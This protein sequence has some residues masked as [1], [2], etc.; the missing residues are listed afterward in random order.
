MDILWNVEIR[1]KM[2][3]LWLGGGG[4]DKN[5]SRK[6]TGHPIAIRLYNQSKY[7]I[8]EVMDVPQANLSTATLGTH[9]HMHHQVISSYLENAPSVRRASVTNR[10]RASINPRNDSKIFQNGPDL[11]VLRSFLFLMFLRT[12]ML[13]CRKLEVLKP[14]ERQNRIPRPQ[15]PRRPLLQALKSRGRRGNVVA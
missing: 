7:I 14:R 4:R 2:T 8:N 13:V 9:I 12:G 3:E 10:K 15:K 11:S 5:G 1:P 6:I